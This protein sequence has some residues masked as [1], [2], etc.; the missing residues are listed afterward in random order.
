MRLLRSVLVGISLFGRAIM[1]LK[2]TKTCFL[3]GFLF[4]S[5][6][7]GEG[8]NRTHIE[9]LEPAV[10]SISTMYNCSTTMYYPS[11]VLCS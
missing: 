5:A 7:G 1:P 10:I 3:A 4:S 6:L 8:G 11:S 2:Y 9:M